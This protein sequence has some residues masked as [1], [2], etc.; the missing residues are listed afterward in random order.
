MKKLTAI[1]LTLCVSAVMM[2]CGEGDT[3]AKKSGGSTPAATP[4]DAGKDKK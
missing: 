4:K 2:G 1:L 3:G